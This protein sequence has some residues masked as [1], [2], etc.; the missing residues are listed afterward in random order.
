MSQPLP[1]SDTAT[2]TPLERALDQN[3]TV[4]DTVEQSSAELA[5]INTVLKQELPGDVKKGDVALALQKTDDLEMRIQDTSQ[6]LAEVN[7][8]LAQEID[9]RVDLENELAATK[10]AL[11]REKAKP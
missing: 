5:V 6:D 11:A 9:A 2:A 7:E 3:T 8:V 4:K 1:Q 10:A